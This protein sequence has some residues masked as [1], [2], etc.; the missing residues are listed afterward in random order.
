MKFKGTVALTAA[1]IVIV[2]YYFLIDVPTEERKIEE[3]TRSAK[4]LLFDSD[5]VEA[6]SIARGRSIESTPL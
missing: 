4:V 1:F 2:L 3:K 6:F 5:N